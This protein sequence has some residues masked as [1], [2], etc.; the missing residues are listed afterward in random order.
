MGFVRIGGVSHFLIVK[1][2][3][4]CESTEGEDNQKGPIPRFNLVKCRHGTE[5]RS[6]LFRQRILVAEEAKS[7]AS[8]V[9]E[10]ELNEVK[11]QLGYVHNRLE[12]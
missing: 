3:Y 4:S 2:K 8:A 6:H 10:A 1:M 5:I 11:Q 9:G 12:H 7:G